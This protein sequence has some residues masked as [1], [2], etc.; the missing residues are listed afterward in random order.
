VKR[1]KELSAAV[2][3]LFLQVICGGPPGGF[4]LKFYGTSTER[5]DGKRAAYFIMPGAD[6]DNEIMMASEGD[7]LKKHFRIVQIGVDKVLLEDTQDHRRQWL[8]MEKE[9]AQ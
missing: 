5:P 7:V 9:N 1:S 3:A 2:L 4:Q 8:N 6:G